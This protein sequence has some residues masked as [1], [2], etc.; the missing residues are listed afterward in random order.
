MSNFVKGVVISIMGAFP[1]LAPQ[2]IQAQAPIRFEDVTTASGVDFNHFSGGSGKHF[3]IETVTAGMATLDYDND[4]LLDL[5]FLNGAPL[6]GRYLDPT[7]RNRLYRNLG[8]F[9][10]VDVTDEAGVGDT[11]FALGVVA[12]D[13]D[14]DGDIDLFISNFGPTVLLENQGDGTFVRREFSHPAK[15]RVGAGLSLLD[16]N[17]DGTLDLYVANYVDFNFEKNVARLIYGVPA[18]PGPRDYQPD[19]DCLYRNE[20]NGVFCDVSQETGIADFA[21]AGMG[22][23][24]FD[25]DNDQDTDIFVCNDSAANFLFQNLGNGKFTESALLAGLAY[26]VLGAEQASMGVDIADYNRDGHLDVIATSFIDEVPVL[27]QNSGD[28][29]FDDL[30]FSAGLGLASRS[31]TWGVGFAD[32]DWDGW[33]DLF[34]A[35]GHLLEG[36]TRLSDRERFEAPNLVLRNEAGK[37]FVDHSAGEAFQVDNAKVSRG[38]V[39]DDL[40]GDGR[41]DVA[42]LNLNDSPQLLRNVTRAEG[43]FLQLELVG[44]QTTRDAAGARVELLDANAPQVQE[45]VLGRGYQSHFGK[46]LNFGIASAERH[47]TAKIVWPDGSTQVVEG[48]APNRRH[49]IVQGTA[50]RGE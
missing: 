26:D 33:P 6:Q 49:V 38:I 16:Y 14:N 43:G 40:D 15:P 1:W 44:T 22:V 45:L 9:R 28:G 24:A 35:S 19:S 4:G 5:Y 31:V 11:G 25:F 27:Y 21:G 10:F 3:I 42:I 50:P 30:G 8:G 20:G 17:R 12:G 34:I 39:L 32:F 41:V 47:P 7:P 2:C 48:L 18:A 36:V 23:I 13:Y 37:Q 46:T 29:Y